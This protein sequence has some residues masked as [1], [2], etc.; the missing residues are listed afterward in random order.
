[1]HAHM[2]I[3]LAILVALI[4]ALVIVKMVDQMISWPV[5]LAFLNWVSLLI[6]KNFEGLFYVLFLKICFKVY[7][8]FESLSTLLNC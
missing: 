1:M 3:L 6:K 5:T 2:C 4:N 8:I 7:N